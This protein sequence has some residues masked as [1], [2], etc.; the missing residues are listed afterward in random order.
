MSPLGPQPSSRNPKPRTLNPHSLNATFLGP[1]NLKP[2]TPKRPRVYV[3]LFILLALSSKSLVDV[4]SLDSM[5]ATEW[6]PGCLQF[7]V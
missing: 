6:T 5:L 3:L 7:R 4:A 1:V 2:Y